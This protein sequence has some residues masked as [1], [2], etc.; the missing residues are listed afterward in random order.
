MTWSSWSRQ[1]FPKGENLW[2][3]HPLMMLQFIHAVHTHRYIYIYTYIHIY[4]EYIYV[5]IYIPCL[6]WVEHI[7]WKEIQRS[8]AGSC[9][10]W[11][12]E[13]QI[14]DDWWVVRI[15]VPSL[16]ACLPATVLHGAQVHVEKMDTK[17]GDGATGGYW[18]LLRKIIPS[19]KKQK[20]PRCLGDVDF[21]GDRGF[22]HL[23]HFLPE[24]IWTCSWSTP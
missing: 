4:I 24:R 17:A 16:P 15:F 6:G 9:W 3:F 10:T 7:S 5:Y 13:G 8:V 22:F 18:R 19:P 21:L 20:K 23:F 1:D 11:F 14:G 2:V 12:W